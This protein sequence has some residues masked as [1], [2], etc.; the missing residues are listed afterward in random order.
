M[1][2]LSVVEQ[3]DQYQ[4]KLLKLKECI[5]STKELELEKQYLSIWN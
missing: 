5:L 2:K 3:L 1:I 4:L